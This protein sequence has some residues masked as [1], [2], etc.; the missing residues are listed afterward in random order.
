M[1]RSKICDMPKRNFELLADNYYHLYNRGVNKQQIFFS[2]RNYHLF[3]GLMRKYLIPHSNIIAYGL[4]PNHF[5]LLFHV[6]NDCQITKSLQVLFMSYAKAI[7]TEQNRVGPLFQGRFQA[8]PIEDDDYLLDCVKYIHLN[9]VKAHLVSDPIR[10]EYS[11]YHDYLYPNPHSLV[12]ASWIL[13]FFD[14]T[15]D[16]ESFIESDID[17]YNSKF[18]KE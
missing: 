7:N 2:D 18:I 11:S 10:W 14:N 6:T 13:N 3:I 15:A 1:N 8:N 17:Q 9:P 5:H 4:L 16:F 12:D